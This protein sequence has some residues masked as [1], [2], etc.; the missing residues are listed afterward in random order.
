MLSEIT[1]LDVDRSSEMYINVFKS[2]EFN[3]EW[4]K[5]EKIKE[6]FSDMINT[7]K[8]LGYIYLIEGKPL[9]YCFGTI[10]DYF[11]LP[12]YYIH[13]IFVD[14]EFQGKGIGKTFMKKIEEDL[15]SR[16]VPMINLLTLN[17]ISAYEFYKKQD[18]IETKASTYM[19]KFLQ[20]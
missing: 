3:F 7:P 5:E 20:S 10:N 6:Y 9:A 8:F 16:N 19:T 18:Y 1:I 12:H 13:E 17:T 4:M 15:L 11:K 2:D 14:T